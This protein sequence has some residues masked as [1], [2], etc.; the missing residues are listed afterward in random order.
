MPVTWESEHSCVGWE[1]DRL[2]DMQ[3]DANIQ[4]VVY[5]L[6]G[7]NF[8]IG[9]QIKSQ[10]RWLN[11][12]IPAEFRGRELDDLGCGDGKITLRLKELF[13]PSSLRGFDV[14]LGLVMR[15]RMRGIEAETLDLDARLPRGELAVMWGVLHHLKDKEACLKRISENYRLAF[16]REPLKNRAIDG[17]EMGKPL[18]KSEIEGLARKY[19]PGARILYNGHCIFIFYVEPGYTPAPAT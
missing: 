12:Q 1:G 19:F 8:V 17:L 6:F 15:A 5:F 11:E 13:Q 4:K 3:I 14:N 16:I 7:T 9:R 2:L 10:I 18:I